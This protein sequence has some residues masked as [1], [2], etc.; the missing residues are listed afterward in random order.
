MPL[1]LLSLLPGLLSPGYHVVTMLT[2]DSHTCISFLPH[3]WLSELQPLS[4]QVHAN[5]FLPFLPCQPRALGCTQARAR[6]TL[7]SGGF[8]PPMVQTF[9]RWEMRTGQ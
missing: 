9:P 3:S 8:N 7:K 4:T 2:P 5:C 1:H 6:V